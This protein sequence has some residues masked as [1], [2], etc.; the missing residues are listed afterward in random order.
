MTAIAESLVP[1]QYAHQRIDAYLAQRFTYLSRT[2]WQREILDGKVIYN[3]SPIINYHKKILEGDLIHY[4]GR[5]DEE[6]PVDPTFSIIYEDKDL[7]GVN[8]SGNLPVHPSGIF[9]ENTLLTIL[10]KNYNQKLH[11]IN[12]IDRETSGIVLF[13]K[14]P[15]ACSAVQSVF[16]NVTKTYISIVHGIPP[17]KE[18]TIDIPLGTRDDARIKKRMY[19]SRDADKPSVTQCKKIFTFEEYSLLKVRPLTGR[20]HQIRAHLNYAGF[21]ILGDKLYGIDENVYLEFVKNGSTSRIHEILGFHR[22]A[23]HSR[24][25]MFQHPILKKIIKIQ[26]PT[27]EDFKKFIEEGR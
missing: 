19:A 23:L 22:C 16:K 13:A 6:P 3:G 11:P 24:S 8:K 25:I 5:F 20:F 17:Q 2:Q 12:R 9:Y 15:R 26:A 7:I 14:N 1:K 27:P 21:P 10:Q 4:L 18:F